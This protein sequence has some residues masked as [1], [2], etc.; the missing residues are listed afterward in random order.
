MIRTL[1]EKSENGKT[2]E[3]QRNAACLRGELHSLN[4]TVRLSL[5]IPEIEKRKVMK[6]WKF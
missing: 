4:P 3:K 5:I 1:P 2:N 6:C